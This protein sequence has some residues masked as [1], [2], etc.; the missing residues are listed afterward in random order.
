MRAYLKIIAFVLLGIAIALTC[1]QTPI[2]YI[3]A[4]LCAL[5]AIFS[6]ALS[7]SSKEE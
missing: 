4:F 6:F 2:N 7:C 1:E 5:I 3:S